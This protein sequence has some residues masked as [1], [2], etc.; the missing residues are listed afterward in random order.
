MGNTA[1]IDVWMQELYILEKTDRRKIYPSLCT[2]LY[3]QPKN[4]G[5]Y[6]T[7]RIGASEDI[8]FCALEID[9]LLLLLL[10]PDVYPVEAPP[11]ST[12]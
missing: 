12:Q 10:L 7:T 1:D 8:L 6:M 2:P 11:P 5:T 3:P 9:S 4:W